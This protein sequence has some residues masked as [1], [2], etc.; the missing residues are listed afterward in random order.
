MI[1]SG[2]STKT[3]YGIYKNELEDGIEKKNVFIQSYMKNDIMKYNPNKI[4][5][6]IYVTS[7]DC[8]FLIFLLIVS[9]SSL[10]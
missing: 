6:T 2:P 1:Q 7:C 8:S 9:C 3:S 4:I 5:I 10:I